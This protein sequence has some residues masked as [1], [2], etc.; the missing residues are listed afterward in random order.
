M[1]IMLL[2]KCFTTCTDM[3]KVLLNVASHLSELSHLNTSWQFVSSNVLP[4]CEIFLIFQSV[5]WNLSYLADFLCFL[6]SN[7][8]YIIVL[9]PLKRFSG[10]NLAYNSLCK[11]IHV[12]YFSPDCLLFL[13]IFT[14]H[15][16]RQLYVQ[17]QQ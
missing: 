13:C 12:F 5:C 8:H 14:F 2:N 3:L 16:S 6:N 4:S 10:S 17:S 11:V 9:S 15:P 7:N 1:F